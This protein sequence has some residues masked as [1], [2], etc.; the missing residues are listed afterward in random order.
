MALRKVFMPRDLLACLRPSRYYACAD[1]GPRTAAPARRAASQGGA[2]ATEGFSFKSFSEHAFYRQVNEWLV[3]SARLK[4]GWRVVD[5]ACGTGQVA[6]LVAEKVRG[7]RQALV[8][9]VDLSLSTVREAMTE[10][11]DTRDVAIRFVAA[12]A[13]E[14]AVA[15]RATAQAVVL[16]NAIHY[17]ADKP[18]LIANVAR[19]LR[20]GGTFAFNTG[21]FKGCNPPET[22][23]FY[24]RWMMKAVRALKRE[25]GLSPTSDRVEARHL[26][27]PE[28]YHDLLEQGGF[29]VE[30]EELLT[31]PMSFEAWRDISR[32]EDFVQGALP[33][34]PLAT[35]SRV[36][37]DALKETFEELELEFVPRRWLSVVAVRA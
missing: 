15:L 8:I 31:A 25:H 9:A 4:P 21:F 1:A 7:G 5:L 33:G 36:L 13:E 20:E 19:N 35:A 34:V 28:E 30:K 10:L 24:R 32:F 2:T 37:C 29:R 18:K 16:C 26:L 12:K 3:E 11:A 23:P 14:F 22:E 17:V 6:R 27:S